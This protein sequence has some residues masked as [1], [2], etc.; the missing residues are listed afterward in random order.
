MSFI[1]NIVGQLQTDY[2]DTQIA[3]KRR[4]IKR[5]KDEGKVDHKGE[6]SMFG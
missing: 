1:K 4:V 5:L 3:V 2:G 6:M